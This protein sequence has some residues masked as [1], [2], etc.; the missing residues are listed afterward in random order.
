MKFGYLF[1]SYVNMKVNNKAD[2]IETTVIKEY[3]LEDPESI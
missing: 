1:T 2:M 3:T